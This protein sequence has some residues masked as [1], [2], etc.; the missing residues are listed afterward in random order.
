VAGTSLNEDDI[1]S[2][3]AFGGNIG[4]MWSNQ[5]DG[6]MYFA[7]HAPGAD[8]ATWTGEIAYSRAQGSDDHISLK[9]DS[10]GQVYAATK[11]SLNAGSDPLIVLS[12]RSTGGTWSNY[13]VS[14]A[15]AAQTRPVVVINEAAG[16]VQVFAAAP[17][18]T[19]GKIYMKQS[20]LAS[21]NFGSGAGTAVIDSSL[22]T[23]I[24]NVSSTKQIISGG[25]GVLI[26]AGDDNTTRYLHNWL[27]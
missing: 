10:A 6:T 22:D 21:I 24:N 17:Q 27:P 3:V 23:T 8:D 2:V 9:V 11:T 14:T 1:S 13:T 26:I 4:V 5:N 20:S 25:M 19:G 12:V 15:A 16:L 7:W 18:Y